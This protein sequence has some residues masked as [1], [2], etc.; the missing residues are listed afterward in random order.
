MMPHR[1]DR[2]TASWIRTLVSSLSLKLFLWLFAV[3]I[4]SFAAYAF[5]NIRTTSEQWNQT[6]SQGARRFSE[7]IQSST[8][9]GMLLNRKE[10]VHHTIRTIARSPGVEGVRIYDKNG[11]II[12]SADSDETGR[13]VDLMAEACVSCHGSDEPL[14]AIPEGN[15]VRIFDRADGTRIL[16]LINPIENA[17][18]CYEAPCHAHPAEQSILGV[19][20]V[21]M[22]M[23][24]PDARLAAAKR[25]AVIAAVLTA[26]L[27]GLF[28]AVFIMRV[29]RRPVKRLITGV[30][31][32]AGGDL[33]TE[34]EPEAPNEIGQL[35]E[36]F[37]NMTRDIRQARQQLTEWSSSLESKLQEKTAEL[38]QSQR[39]VAHMEKM[40]SLGKLAATVA[41]ELNNP[42]AGILNYAKLVDRTLRESPAP[43]PE[44][45]ELDRYLNLIQ[46]EAAR[47]GVIVRNLLLFARRS[48][49][50]FALHSLNAILE[51]SVMLVRHH[52]EMSEIRL[53]T[54]PIED[55]DRIVCDADQIQQAL[56]ALLVNAIEAMPNGGMLQLSAELVGTHVSIMI[57]DSGVGISQE[58]LPHI[59][60]PFFSSKEETEGAGLGLAVV[61]GIVQRHDGRIDVDSEVGRGTT[62]RV[63]LP[64]RPA[65]EPSSTKAPVSREQ[66]AREA[67][68]TA[69]SAG[70]PERS[71]T[72]GS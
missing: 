39:Q 22:S 51:R 26:L 57:R 41:H 62:F 21:K 59:F 66:A 36:A 33:D 65:A 2:S 70:R 49:A 20:D 8:H 12:F 30:E 1:A 23:A 68:S 17:P 38:S 61:Y 45:K 27:A 13:R 60:E 19:L 56:V 18:E 5:I 25:Q 46:K 50:E 6:I 53:E 43:H 64:R 55:D 40:A 72:N 29:V 37:N 48:G 15:R 3:I 31:K 28:S 44:T 16:G 47:S 52:L 67:V 42:L 4:V 32:V 10:D 9:Y 34:I 69:P 14:R 63:S 24:E 7:L 35:A 11:V 71:E 54:H 58:A